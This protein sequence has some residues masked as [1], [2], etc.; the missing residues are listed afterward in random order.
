MTYN[1]KKPAVTSVI[2]NRRYFVIALRRS[3]ILLAAKVTV[4]VTKF[5]P[6]SCR[7]SK[8]VRGRRVREYRW[9]QLREMRIF[10]IGESNPSV[11]F[12]R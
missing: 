4:D 7:P 3:S 6:S 1:N 9:F 10:K 2:D 8:V 5:G 11:L 12:P